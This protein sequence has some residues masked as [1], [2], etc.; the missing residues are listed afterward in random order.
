MRHF[1]FLFIIV[2]LV[3]CATTLEYIPGYQEKFVIDFTK[4]RNENFLITPEKYNGEY[5]SIGVL[6]IAFYPT[7]RKV[8]NPESVKGSEYFNI[9]GLW[10]S[11]KFTAEDVVDIIYNEAKIMGADAII[12][13]KTETV[14]KP[15]PNFAHIGYKVNGFAIKRK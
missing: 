14:S 2:I 10:V 8:N 13:L 12:N 3:G 11:E 9:Q 1:L 7:A 6:S 4:Y 15:Y 5:E